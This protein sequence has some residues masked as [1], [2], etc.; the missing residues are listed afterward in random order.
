MWIII[1]L[2]IIV[3]V[4]LAFGRKAAGK[5]ILI[6]FTLAFVG[7]VGLIVW[8]MTTYPSKPYV[9]LTNNTVSQNTW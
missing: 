9:P 1:F 2:L 6:T 7:F 3:G 8:V 4:W 5:T